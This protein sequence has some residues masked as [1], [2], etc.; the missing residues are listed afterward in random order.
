MKIS[1]IPLALGLSLLTLAPIPGN[2]GNKVKSRIAKL[3]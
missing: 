2:I 3:S 1:L